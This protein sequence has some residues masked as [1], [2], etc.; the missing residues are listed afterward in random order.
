MKWTTCDRCGKEI[1]EEKRKRIWKDFAIYRLG[2]YIC[3]SYAYS[4]ICQDCS[5][6]FN[7]WFKNGKETKSIKE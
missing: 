7:E 4:D 6:S 2:F 3:D 5:D 1:Q